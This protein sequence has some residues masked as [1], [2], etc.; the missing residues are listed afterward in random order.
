MIWDN[1]QN[2][3]K[4]TK[5]EKNRSNCVTYVVVISILSAVI[6]TQQL[7]LLSLQPA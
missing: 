1:T 6:S 2:Y 3:I 5:H 7:F 4:K